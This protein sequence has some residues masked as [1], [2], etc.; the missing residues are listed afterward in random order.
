M[1]GLFAFFYVLLHFL[2]WLILDQDLYWAGILPRH[3]A[4]GRS[5]RSASSRCCC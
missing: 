5:S 3:R 4:S 1:L 2:T